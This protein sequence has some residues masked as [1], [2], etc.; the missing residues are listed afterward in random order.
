[1]VVSLVPFRPTVFNPVAVDLGENKPEDSWNVPPGFP[2][3]ESVDLPEIEGDVVMD[4]ANSS[5]VPMDYSSDQPEMG[6]ALEINSDDS[7]IVPYGFPFDDLGFALEIERQALVCS[8]PSALCEEARGDIENPPI[9]REIDALIG[10][11]LAVTEEPTPEAIVIS[12]GSIKPRED[13]SCPP[14][15]RPVEEAVQGHIP[16]VSTDEALI[17]IHFY[18]AAKPSKRRGFWRKLLSKFTCFGK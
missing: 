9:E 6:D 4:R 16:S 11:N 8:I 1:M 18:N 2:F 15:V 12:E 17:P 7:W 3:D 13:D 14:M 5:M 10:S